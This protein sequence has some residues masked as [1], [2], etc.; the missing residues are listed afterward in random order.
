MRAGRSRPFPLRVSLRTP[1]HDAES[2]IDDLCDRVEISGVC[3]EERRAGMTAGKRDED[4][5]H[6]RR[7]R[8]V[9]AP[10]PEV[11]ESP[12]ELLPHGS[13][14][15]DET[16]RLA[17]SLYCAPIFARAGASAELHQDHR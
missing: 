4:V 13:R 9:E 1:S 17:K 3:R 12:T 14:W 7:A 11:S 8:H 10:A 5:A 2:K 16:R 15:D 6:E